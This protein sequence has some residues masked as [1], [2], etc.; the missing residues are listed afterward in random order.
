MAGEATSGG[1]WTLIPPRRTA[2]VAPRCTFGLALA[3]RALVEAGDAIAAGDPLAERVT[4]VTVVELGPPLSGSFE[5]GAPV[6][7]ASLVGQVRGHRRLRLIDRAT[8]LHRAPDGAVRVAVGRLGETTTA[9][10]AGTVESVDG[11]GIVVRADGDGLAA[12][13]A[14]G[15]P[16]RGP[17]ILAVRGPDEELRA[18]GVDVSVAGAVIVAGARIDIEALTRARALGVRGVICGGIVG[19][20]LRQLEASEARQ[21]ASLHPMAGFGLAVIDGYGRRPIP[22]PTWDALTAAAGREVAIVTDPPMVVLDSALPHR[23]T[24]GLARVIA[25]EHLG[26]EG[27]VLD[28]RGSVRTS[29][30]GYQPA[31]LVRLNGRTPSE[32]P[33]QR[34]LALTDL[35]RLD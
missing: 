4:D 3:D 35:E 13:F 27:R 30:A 12:A 33:E 1:A 15:G 11:R 31:A 5:P 29:A 6:D 14:W 25:G 23:A 24:S 8:V 34:I 10:I 26:R 32:P 20:D 28:L 21:R 9:P 16:V 22:G 2:V 18:G 19:K 7:P 17:L